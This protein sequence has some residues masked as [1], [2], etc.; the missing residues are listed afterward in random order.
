MKIALV[1]THDPPG[2]AATACHRLLRG[3]LS[4]GADCALIVKE[5]RRDDSSVICINPGETDARRQEYL[6]VISLVQSRYIDQNRTNISN[7]IFTLPYPGYDLSVTPA[8]RKADIINLHWVAG[9]Q[10]PKSIGKLLRLGK[11]VVWTLHDMRPFTGGCHFSAGCDGYRSDC[12]VCPQL[13]DDPFGLPEAV[14]KEEL[15][16][17]RDSDITIVSP[18]RW[19]A[20]CAKESSLFRSLRIEMIPYGI[21]TEMFSPLE[22]RAAK[23]LMGIDDA[24]IVVLF[25]AENLTEI[26]KGTKELLEAL[27]YCLSDAHFRALADSDSVSFMA[28]GGQGA[29]FRNAAVPWTRLGYIDSPERM[30]L[31]YAASDLYILPSL[32]DNLP[33]AVLEAMACGTPVVAFRTGGTPDMIEDGITGG[34]V[35]SHSATELGEAIMRLIRDPEKLADMGQAARNTVVRNFPLEIQARRYLD[36]FEEL[37]ETSQREES[38]EKLS[39]GRLED[40]APRQAPTVLPEIEMGP[41]VQHA[42]LNI[43]VRNLLQK[44]KESQKLMW[45]HDAVIRRRAKLQQLLLDRLAENKV[46]LRVI[47]TNLCYRFMTLLAWAYSSTPTPLHEMLRRLVTKAGL[48]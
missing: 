20:A 35:E 43:A 47:N 15:E 36:L 2:G 40:E 5:K 9:F 33:G 38:S 17:L 27:R 42:V 32:E 24:R 16:L 21:D 6:S 23:R 44:V 28:F 37:L 10:S 30:R 18:S 39:E 34:L 22:K 3:L 45:K 7:T 8:V 4:E 46:L 31:A 41:G 1:N 13:K 29:A 19:L 25:G 14:L 12:A 48:Q 11:P 26:R